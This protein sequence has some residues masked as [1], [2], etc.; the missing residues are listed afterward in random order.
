MA[1]LS[2]TPGNDTLTGTVTD[3][4]LRGGAGD[5][6]LIGNGGTDV[7]V[8]GGSFAGYRFGW[9][10]GRLTVRDIDRGD[11]NDGEDAL[12]GIWR[13]QFADREI[14]I[15][16][17]GVLQIDAPGLYADGAVS[18]A[19]DDGSFVMVWTDTASSDLLVQR[20][21]AD[22]RALGE[23][24]TIDRK[25]DENPGQPAITALA[26]GGFAVAWTRFYPHFSAGYQPRGLYT[27]RFD[28]AGDST[29]AVVRVDPLN[30]NAPDEA[31]LC[32]LGDGGF[33]LAWTSST[34]NGT[35]LVRMQRFDAGGSTQGAVFG[36]ND[37][38]VQEFFPHLAE[39]ADGSVLLAWQA[40]GGGVRTQRY[41]AN[42]TTLGS[43]LVVNPD[44][45]AD[46]QPAV[47]GLAD[48]GYVLAW[49]AYGSS[50]AHIY[51][52]RFDADGTA[53]GAVQRADK[54]GSDY[55]MDPVVVVLADGG[56]V[57]AWESQSRV[58]AR[59]YGADGTV[60]GSLIESAGSGR[61]AT[62]A[63][64]GDGG[65]VLGWSGYDGVQVQRYHAD[66]TPVLPELRGTA[67]D[68][69]IDISGGGALR[70]VG[71]AGDDVYRIASA[72]SEIVEAVDGGHDRVVSRA[73]FKLPQNVEELRLT[74]ARDIA[75]T[76]R[77]GDEFIG[78]NRGDNTLRGLA[79]NDTLEGGA[80]AD[81]LDGG[82]GADLLR[83]G[84]G[85]DLYVVDS[86]DDRVQ[87]NGGGID[88]VRSDLDLV[89]TDGLE[90][91][92]LSGSA[93]VGTGNAAANRIRGNA[94]DNILAGR[95]GNDTLE[96]GG[97]ADIAVFGG[98]H[99]GYRF[100]FVDGVLTVG[101]TRPWDGDDG[102]D[103]LRQIVRMRFADGDLALES[104]GMLPVPVNAY[105]SG[106]TTLALAD[107]T[108]VAAWNH[109][110][111]DEVWTQRWSADGTPIG[112][113]ARLAG[114]SL[115]EC[116]DPALAL[117]ADGG[118]FASWLSLDVDTRRIHV[119]VRSFAED[120]SPLGAA[121]ML[122]RDPKFRAG[123]ES[124]LFAAD[125]G[126]VVAWI[127]TNTET[128]NTV[129]LARRLDAAGVPVGDAFKVNTLEAAAYGRI[130]G[131]AL[132]DGGFALGWLSEWD[133]PGGPGIMQRRFDA[134]GAA[135]GEEMR[136][137]GF[138]STG[139][140]P[141]I[142]AL[143]DGGHA[144][145]WTGMHQ[146]TEHVL[147]QRYGTDGSA[148]GDAFVADLGGRN[149]RTGAS[150][151]ALADGTLLVTWLTGSTVRTGRI[152][153]ADGTALT[154]EILLPEGSSSFNANPNGGFTAARDYYGALSGLAY[155][156]QGLPLWPLLH[157]TDEANRIDIGGAGAMRAAGHGGD[158]RYLVGAD[159][160]VIEQ[161]GEG[162]DTIEA[163]VSF[164]LP[165]HVEV[166][167]LGG[168]GNANGSAGAGNQRL[169]GNGAGNRL[170]GG[171]GVDTLAGGAGDDVYVV[172][173]AGDSI[174]EQGGGIDE[175]RSSVSWTL[176]VGQDDLVLL[177]HTAVDAIGNALPNLI[178][179]NGRAN[180]LAGGAGND[181]LLGGG[182]DDVARF[183]GDLLDHRITILPGAVRVADI[184]LR[185]GDDGI[186]FLSGVPRLRFA[187]TEVALRTGGTIMVNT[188]IG[189][190]HFDPGIAVL[191]D[192][193]Y[194]V[195]W[196]S[197]QQDGSYS[198]IYAQRFAADGARVGGEFLVST[199]TEGYQRLPSVTAL[200]GGGFVVGWHGAASS[201]YG[202]RFQCFGA[203]GQ[204]AG[205]AIYP[206]YQLTTELPHVAPTA[207][208]GFAH[209]WFSDGTEPGWH[210]ER[211][212]A[213]GVAVGSAYSGAT[214]GMAQNDA[215][216]FFAMPD[217]R[218]GVVQIGYD[219]NAGSNAVFLQLFD[220]D[221]FATGL[222]RRVDRTDSD[223]IVGATVS[224]TPDGGL[225]IGWLASRDT[226]TNFA[227]YDFRVQRYAAD[228]SR[229]GGETRVNTSDFY[230]AEH[231]VIAALDDGG[232]VAAWEEVRGLSEIR[233]QVF[234]AQGTKVGEE[235]S[236]PTGRPELRSV[237]LV[238]LEGG[239]FVLGWDGVSAVRLAVVD[240]ALVVPLHG[241]AANDVL[242]ASGD[243]P[244]HAEGGAGNDL[245]LVTHAADLTVEDPAAG[246]DR[247][248]STVD[249]TLA[250][251]VEHLLLLDGDAVTA[252]GNE[253][254]NELI[255]NAGANLLSARQGADTLD[256]GTGNDTL[257]GGTDVDQFRFST[258]LSGTGNRDLVT[259][260]VSGTDVI[261][262]DDDV[263]RALDSAGSG[264]L[265][266][267]QFHAAPGATAA[268]DL[269]DRI[270]YDTGTGT[271]YYDP[272]GIAGQS[273]V[274]FAVLG[275]A[276]HPV[277]T[278][279]DFLVVG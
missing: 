35:S 131:T 136:V 84:A 273:A 5:D 234:D 274:A 68:D 250:A 88:T 128:G 264:S 80:G 111:L 51:V 7:A 245:Y 230:T 218:F 209:L 121:I 78:G 191:A 138:T 267:G 162:N 49:V 75:G 239:E 16:P 182:G 45:A 200:A 186:D 207:D 74:G 214:A 82:A 8:F 6:R 198:D 161:A 107:G 29:G 117:R 25:T 223:L 41:A 197:Y 79:G 205:A 61:D 150:L 185:G 187:D 240:G 211:F 100:G 206:R 115:V 141:A 64:L 10:D 220:A 189:S 137:A 99:E 152:F 251:N 246:I 63:T 90:H 225:V 232:F 87:E 31:T 201:G 155:D 13:L 72:A 213:T 70:A 122:D 212:D 146:G 37:P 172:D 60:R 272:D 226:T 231:P 222:T 24:L 94:G 93:V 130:V 167:L 263:F 9:R 276:T 170:D 163:S 255:G 148:L 158:D 244:M 54:T 278:A 57:V 55:Y 76:G 194:V 177:G 217:G 235:Q 59:C 154:G 114:G 258:T 265:P 18:A 62:L 2:G 42:G 261:V 275:S 164:T 221:G 184:S 134:E 233:L 149:D 89:L 219:E 196:E 34:D 69:A 175:V 11:G 101:D 179:G 109:G 19:L 33:V 247:V 119:M 14:D 173:D 104:H 23:A 12:S 43:T 95:A 174:L 125:D 36:P 116:W 144:V 132:A 67:G 44:G 181:S 97:G 262:L 183:A 208:G 47:A 227:D 242:G 39:L 38:A 85:D 169:E 139:D 3:D 271:L 145:A 140:G 58:F 135:L 188:D 237:F 86:A 92:E 248:Q 171:A 193:G 180:T 96:G 269:N 156:A 17:G 105:A 199:E 178:T 73:P 270:V 15:A 151:L 157:G 277:L 215:I 159:D 106:L 253:A 210:I 202:P 71:G 77:D 65:F 166:L 238:G 123:P 260:F 50:T 102:V 22:G 108:T 91:L 243:M 46:A 216:E 203:D 113:P 160:V 153:D 53:Q 28:A 120:G 126:L 254:A 165:D 147:V 112:A 143:G 1:T 103:E 21:S 40:G 83:G 241:D 252:T 176:G 224:V 52:R 190:D 81:T 110:G 66:G 118:Y 56:F 27:Q 268:H 30:T 249:W 4:T 256:G 204:P 124:T 266:S 142:A 229:L 127:A 236:L 259:D 98:G 32:P 133:V 48:G 228:G 195:V 192:G 26:D 20:F 129:V 279:S 168:T 257:T